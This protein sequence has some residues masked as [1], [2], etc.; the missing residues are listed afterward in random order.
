MNSLITMSLVGASG[1]AGMEF[2]RLIVQHPNLMLKNIYGFSS[3]GKSLE[4]IYPALQKV[5]SQKIASVESVLNDDSDLIV[6]TLPHGKSAEW[7]YKLLESGYKGKILDVGSDFRLYNPEDYQMYYGYK[8]AYP[9]ILQKFQYGLPEF[10]KNDILKSSYVANPGCFATA[11]QLALLPL[12]LHNCTESYHVT[13]MTGSSGSGAKLSEAVHFS[14]R[15]GNVKA[16][17]VLNHQ[18]MSEL[19]QSAK[20]LKKNN[21]DVLFTPLSGPFVRGIWMTVSFIL[22]KE[23]SIANLYDSAYKNSPFIR[24]GQ[25]MP[26]LNHVV[27]SNFVDIGWQQDGSHVVVGIALDNL[28]KGASGQAIQNINLMFGL[29]ETTGLTQPGFI[30]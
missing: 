13:G 3:A 24:I 27:G 6:F 9:E 2:L 14:H 25:Y 15:F 23:V 11:I 18:H 10:F 20:I 28:I 5:Y 17:K 8:H 30:L 26:E 29:N 21:P 12:I 19:F 4:D 22:S 7:I 1:F 16:Y